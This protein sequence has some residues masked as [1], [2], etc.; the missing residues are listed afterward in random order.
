MTDTPIA[1][2]EMAA[3]WDGEEGAGWAA[4]AEHYDDAGE[5]YNKHLLAHIGADDDVLDIGCGNGGTTRA[6][7]AVAR[8]ATGI[9]LSSQMLAYAR[10]K[11]EG[12]AN[13]DFIQGDAQVYPFEP[14]SFDVVISRQGAMFFADPVAAFANIGRALRPSGRIAI[15]AWQSLADNEWLSATREALAMGRELPSAPMGKPGPFG[16]ADPDADRRIFTEAGYEDIS[17]E[18]VSELLR[19][20]ADADDAYAFISN[21]GPVRGMLADLSDA[22]KQQALANLRPVIDAH[23]TDDGVLFGSRCWLIA[24]Q[25]PS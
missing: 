4:D 25:R 14:A 11:S 5:R 19:M 6:A 21:N 12:L 22:D 13:V 10:A 23:A 7:A 17:V 16:L 1:N 24:A 9:D 15:L 2:V 18:D 20:G 3:A 8:S